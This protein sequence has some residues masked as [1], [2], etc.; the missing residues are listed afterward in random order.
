M[1]LQQD[2]NKAFCIGVCGGSSAGKSIISNLISQS[3]K[4]FK[5]VVASLKQTDFYKNPPKNNK[6]DV[7]KEYNFDQPDAVDWKHMKES[8]ETLIQR[9]DIHIPQYDINQQ[10]R[11]SETQLMK[12]ADVIVV[13]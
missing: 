9:K 12:K 8:L 4:E 3:L 11:K 6:N 2:N 13:E 10:E 7:L 5:L 1:T